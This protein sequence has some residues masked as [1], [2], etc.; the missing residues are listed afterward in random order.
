MTSGTFS[1]ALACRHAFHGD[2]GPD[3]NIPG[4]TNNKYVAHT[5]V[6]DKS[7]EDAGESG[8]RQPLQGGFELPKRLGN[9]PG[10]GTG[11]SIHHERNPHYLP[12]VVSARRL[13][14]PPEFP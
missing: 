8:R 7:G 3:N 1:S 14:R 4:D 2:A 11:L 6:E 9:S 5:S 12:S 13:P 10:C